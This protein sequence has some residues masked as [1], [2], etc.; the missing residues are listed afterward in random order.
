MST[1]G[2]NVEL[3]VVSPGSEVN[4]TC[5][6]DANFLLAVANLSYLM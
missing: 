4:E 1:V 2:S 3:C 5:G 6:S